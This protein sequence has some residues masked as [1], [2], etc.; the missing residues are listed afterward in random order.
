MLLTGKGSSRH[1]RNPRCMPVT[2]VNVDEARCL[3]VGDRIQV[4]FH[5]LSWTISQVE[6]LRPLLEHCAEDAFLSAI[7]VAQQQNAKSFELRAALSLAKLHQSAGRTAD[8]HAVL[9]QAV[10]GFSPT[11]EFPQIR[12]A[13]TLLAALV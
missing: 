9:A 10:E 12:E 1:W 7:A 2:A 8:A 6:V 13:Q 5:P 11:P 3:R 4:P